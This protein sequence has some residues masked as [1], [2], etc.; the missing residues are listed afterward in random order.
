MAT[1]LLSLSMPKEAEN[2]KGQT[3]DP[4]DKRTGKEGFGV[5]ETNPILSTPSFFSTRGVVLQHQLFLERL[6][7]KRLSQYIQNPILSIHG[8]MKDFV[9]VETTQH[10]LLIP[11]ADLI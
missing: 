2:I 7:G 9:F 6:T 11:T 10:I 1:E 3:L 8:D 5:D 4:L